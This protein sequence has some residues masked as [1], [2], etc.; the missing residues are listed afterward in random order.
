MKRK[1]TLHCKNNF[2]PFHKV[3]TQLAMEEAGYY[4]Y[5]FGVLFY[6]RNGDLVFCCENHSDRKKNQ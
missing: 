4:M 1:M 5:Y 2:V 3:A 6:K